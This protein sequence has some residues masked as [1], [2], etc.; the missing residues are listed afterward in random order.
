VAGYLVFGA[1]TAAGPF[2][3]LTPSAPGLWTAATYTDPVNY[4]VHMVRAV[5]LE[6]SASGTYYNPSEG[7]FFPPLP[8]PGVLELVTAENTA[9]SLPAAKLAL[10]GTSGSGGALS[11]TAVDSTSTNGGTVV[12]AGGSITYTPS[13]NFVGLDSFT[14]TLFDGAGSAQGAENVTV[15]LSNPPA[16]NCLSGVLVPGGGFFLE[17]L[18]IPGVAYVVQYTLDSGVSWHDLSGSLTANSTGLITFT[19][20]HP[21]SPEFYRTR[22]GP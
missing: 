21:Q 15:G 16:Q 7:I 18:G 14:Y 8:T 19:D 5:N 17:F 1:S 13:N 11:I 9:V 3:Q 4:A 10:V 12:L 20:P 2:T 22:L 6:S